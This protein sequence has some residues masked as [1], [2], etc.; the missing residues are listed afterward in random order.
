MNEPPIVPRRE[1]NSLGTAGF[2]VSM[3]GLVCSLGIL[4]PVGLILSLV[5]LGK[6]PRGF[7]VAG[8]VIGAL[9]SCGLLVA[10]IAIPAALA[11]VLAAAGLTAGAAAVAAFAGPQVEAKV[12]MFVLYTNVEQTIQDHSGALPATLGEATSTLSSS[13][14]TDPWG[15][16]Y[17]YEVTQN[18]AAYRLYS[19]GPDKVAGTPD[20]I[21]FEWRV[22]INNRPSHLDPTPPS[23]PAALPPSEAPASEN[24]PE[25]S[26]DPGTPAP[27][28]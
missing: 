2:V 16:A 21:P 6:K 15:S 17:G 8:V 27:P 1:T 5:A 4:S 13:Q 26:A 24:A 12:E 25:T 14:A 3:I 9:G 20:D 23:G 7:A 18:G 10:L 11:L 19:C 22:E 28:S